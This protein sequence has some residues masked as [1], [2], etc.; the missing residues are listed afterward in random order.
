MSGIRGGSDEP[1]EPPPR[2]RYSRRRRRRVRSRIVSSAV[3]SRGLSIEE[4]LGVVMR[5][6]LNVDVI[7]Q[8]RKRCGGGNLH[9]ICSG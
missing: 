8:K 3:Y 9:S 2:R 6:G 1:A 5:E 4:Y 7:D